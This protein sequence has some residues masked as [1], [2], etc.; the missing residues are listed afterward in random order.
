MTGEEELMAEVTGV[1]VEAGK[2]GEGER[3]SI[4]FK[5]STSS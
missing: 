3:V 2:G 1:D 4:L 5:V